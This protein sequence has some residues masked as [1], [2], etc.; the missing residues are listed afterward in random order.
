M[1][2]PPFTL[3]QLEVFEM[4]CET[5]SFRRAS[6]ELGIS[7]ASVSNQL[8]ALEEQM[9][10]R[11]LTR[12]SGRR[13]QLTH[14][15]AGFLADLGEFWR[16]AD[17]LAAHRRGKPDEGTE[18]ILLKLLAGNYL[19][20]DNIRPKL[21][22]FLERHPAIQLDFVSPTISE[23]ATQMVAR[24]SYDLGL[25]HE[26]ASGSLGEGISELA[27]VRC[28]VFG[29]RSH[30]E[31][32][33][34]LL[35]A[36]EVSALPFL[37]PPAGTPYENLILSML[38]REGINPRKIVGRTQYF[39]VMSAMFDRSDSIGVVLE[40]ILRREHRNVALLYRL[41]D[42]RLAFYRNPRQTDPRSRIVE[43]FLIS[44]VLDDP[45]F[46][47]LRDADAAVPGD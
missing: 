26:P 33:N 46:P 43:D 41:K 19:L 35:A 2:A 6:E 9:G 23:T 10:L 32:R 17:A 8:K 13:P 28:G 21:D 25:F 22:R 37:L 27:R 45:S 4:L 12:D 42:W 16:T 38:A 1:P 36:D 14:E 31:G 15:G 39:D 24:G 20:R 30:L 5:R 34:D 7:Q 18:P 11:L 40:P 47:A 29:N 3:R 44:A